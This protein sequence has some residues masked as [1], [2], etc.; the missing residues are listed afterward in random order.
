MTKK[1]NTFSTLN[2]INVSKYVEKKGNFNYLSWSFAV[3]ELLKV[4][5]NA[6]WE[7]HTFR[8]PE[9]IDQPYMRTDTGYFVQVTVD[10]DSVKRTQVH[11]V[12]DNRNSP[13]MKPN[14]FHINTSIQRCLAKAIALHGL[15]LYIYAGEDLPEVMAT[16][17]QFKKI[18]SLLESDKCTLSPDEKDSA[19]SYIEKDITS[20]QA[21][22]LI[23]K[24]KSK[25]SS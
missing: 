7:V 2:Q 9:G 14:A 22:A 13:I 16:T 18:N 25:M 1:D 24:L 8:T 12:L 4:C 6:T 11:P 15:G 23:A 10:V 21:E 3:Q 20:Q 17:A 5:P 19:L